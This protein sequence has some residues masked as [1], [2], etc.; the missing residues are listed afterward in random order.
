MGISQA[1]VGLGGIVYPIGIELMMEEYG[2]RGK[3]FI[4]NFVL[5][6]SAGYTNS[7]ILI[8]SKCTVASAEAHLD[9]I[10]TFI[11]QKK[12]KKFYRSTCYCMAL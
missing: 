2:F 4:K 9:L 3:F 5:R 1:I 10:H 11:K 12:N 6:F 8:K 7:K